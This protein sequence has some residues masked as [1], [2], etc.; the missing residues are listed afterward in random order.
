MTAVCGCLARPQQLQ[1]QGVAQVVGVDALLGQPLTG[2]T[3]LQGTEDTRLRIFE[4]LWNKDRGVAH[5]R[6]VGT[7]LENPAHGVAHSPDKF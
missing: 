7:L 1:Q 6:G 5:M 4:N 2:S 3:G